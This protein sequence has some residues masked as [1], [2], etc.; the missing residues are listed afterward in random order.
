MWDRDTLECTKV[1]SGH[2]GSV[3]CLQYNEYMII[4]GSVDSTIR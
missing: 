4:S 1:L 2:T 3:L